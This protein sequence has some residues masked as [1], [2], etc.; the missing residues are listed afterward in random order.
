VTDKASRIWN[1]TF[2]FRPR[3]PQA[4][5]DVRHLL[6]IPEDFAI[7]PEAEDE[8]ECLNLEITCPPVSRVAAGLPVLVWIHGGSQIVTFCSAQSKICGTFLESAVT[9][10]HPRAN[11]ITDRPN[12]DCSRLYQGGKADHLCVD[13]LP[14]QHLQLRGWQRK[15]P[16]S[17]GSAAGY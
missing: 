1:L 6:R 9:E 8:F 13:Q 17:K 12:K 14:S 4:N 11:T 5:V 16:S 3:C 15:E 10:D 7:A 2:C